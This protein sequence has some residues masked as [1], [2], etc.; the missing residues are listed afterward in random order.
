MN[1]RNFEN[2]YSFFAASRDVF[3]PFVREKKMFDGLYKKIIAPLSP[4]KFKKEYGAI[5]GTI[6]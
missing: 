6:S 1:V 2:W 4:R 5:K 3:I